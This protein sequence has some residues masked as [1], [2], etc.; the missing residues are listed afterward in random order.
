MT[1]RKFRENDKSSF[2]KMCHE[3][4]ASGAALEPIP[5]ENMN[6]TFDYIIK[7]GNYVKGFIFEKDGKT[8]GYGLVIVYYSNAVGGLCG[9]LDEIY[10][11]PDFQGSGIG[12]EYLKSI[13]TILDEEIIGIRLEVM[14]TN[15]RA[16]KLYEKQGFKPL[17]YKQLV[18]GANE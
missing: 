7:D 11:S 12:S 4:Y 8:A 10:V 3:F 13:S 14:D 2:I 1:I 6:D 9:L 5:E 17:D 15:K 16:I 18:K